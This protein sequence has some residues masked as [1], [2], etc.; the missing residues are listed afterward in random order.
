MSR[1]NPEPAE[2]EKSRGPRVARR[3]LERLDEY[4]SL[5]RR[6]QSTLPSIGLKVDP[7]LQKLITSADGVRGNL[8]LAAEG[9]VYHR[10]RPKNSVPNPADS[11]LVFLDECGAHTLDAKSSF[12]VFCLAAVI[13]REAA[14]QNLDLVVRAWK[15][16]T[17]NDPDFVIHEPEIRGRV[18]PWG[19]PDRDALLELMRELLAQLDFTMVA[20][21]VRRA[22]Y[23]RE[24]GSGALD[25]SLPEH[26]Y[27]MALDFLVERTLMVLESDFKGGRG[28]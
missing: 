6:A 15:V 3:K 7:I 5:L 4:V 27:L 1:I 8:Q 19:K 25:E 28:K 20:C 22:E 23:L 13:V 16:T 9:R 17:V 12:P 21:V 11:C 26:P 24:F 10:K 14:W 18:G 2:L